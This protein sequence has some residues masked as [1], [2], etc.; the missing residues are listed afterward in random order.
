[1]LG[2]LIAECSDVGCEFL[3]FGDRP[4]DQHFEGVDCAAKECQGVGGVSGP[5]GGID[6]WWA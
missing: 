1:M 4:Y 6:A 3:P 5:F 2:L